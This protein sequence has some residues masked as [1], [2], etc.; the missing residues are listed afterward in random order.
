MSIESWSCHSASQD[1]GDMLIFKEYETESS[2]YHSMN[3]TLSRF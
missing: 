3:N 2:V 1:A